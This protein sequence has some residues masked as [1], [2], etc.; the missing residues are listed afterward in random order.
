[1]S[2]L[3]RKG[4][5]PDEVPSL[6]YDPRSPEGLA[7][8][9]VQWVAAAGALKN[10]LEDDTGE[11]AAHNQPDD[12]WFLAGSYGKAVTRQCLVPP[13]RELF[14]P[15]FNMWQ[16][17]SEGPPPVVEGA[18]G[19]LVVDGV[20]VEPEAVATPIPFTV[21][22]ARL[23][24]VTGRK[25]PVALTVWGLWKLLAP[26]SPGEHELRA[27][28]GDGHGFTVDVTYRLR[29]GTTAIDYPVR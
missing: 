22:G 23:N 26:L 15:V 24:G 28:G 8:R 25:R 7:A 18:F 9:W 16:A 14:L 17:A 12:V 2:F 20:P 3:S 19:S 21:A 13:G 6:P 1:M 4:A 27:V 10:P 5:D 11:H 29:V